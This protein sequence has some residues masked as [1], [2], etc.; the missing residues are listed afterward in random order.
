MGFNLTGTWK[1]IEDFS[2]GDSEGV[3]EL[4]HNGAV[5]NATLE[6]T[7][8]PLE[9]DSYTIKQEL[10]GS[11]NTEENIFILNAKSFSVLTSQEEI[12]YELDSF[13]AQLI[14]EDLIVGTT[15]DKQGVVGV[16]SFKRL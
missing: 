4:T 16:F 5:L 14:N 9:G 3:L 11:I 8:K 6:H 15:E 12:D 13:E 10:V 2:Y 7:E 1:Y